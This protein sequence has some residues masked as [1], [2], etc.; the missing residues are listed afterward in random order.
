MPDIEKHLDLDLKS[1]SL[2]PEQSRLMLR[3]VL[4]GAC[5]RRISH[6]MNNMI[7]GIQGYTSLALRSKE[8]SEK[9]QQY[10]LKVS[11]CCDMTIQRN[12]ELLALFHANYEDK[13]SDLVKTLHKIISFYNRF[14]SDNCQVEVVQSNFWPKTSLN[15]NDLKE[16]LL[17]LIL[18][19]KFEINTAGR[20]RIALSN[21][22][23]SM[24]RNK[25]TLSFIP[26][27][28]T[29]GVNESDKKGI[30]KSVYQQN[31][32]F[33]YMEVFEPT[34]QAMIESGGGTF[35]SSAFQT[36]QV[37]YVIDLPIIEI[38]SEDRISFEKPKALPI[39]LDR[40]RIL[41]IEDQAEIR[42][43][44]ESFLQEE[45]H[46]TLSFENGL[47]FFETIQVKD[48]ETI[49]LFLLDVF[50]PSVSG[51]EIA[52]MIREKL[53]KAKILFCSALADE[54]SI[55]E[56]IKFDAITSILRKPFTK[57]DLI[58]KCEHYFSD[59]VITD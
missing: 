27:E 32:I 23:Q 36:A 56:H 13:P 42:E 40:K 16:I 3:D 21:S 9:V 5:T 48:M 34:I 43:L 10:L 52:L 30:N 45:G 17:Y 6:D 25:V 26:Y 44:I 35:I 46:Q 15:E 33:F 24:Y 29:V 39:E 50:L 8:T 58:Q 19:L 7:S 2:S 12:N 51:V 11:K 49:D 31:N 28:S 38:Q 47:E 41:I 20:I 18:K 4:L 1:G 57:E 59:S 54:E 53:P 14:Y 22:Q 37:R 55:Q